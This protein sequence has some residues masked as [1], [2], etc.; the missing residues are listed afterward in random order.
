M[1]TRKIIVVP[2]MV[3]NWLNVSGCEKVVVRDGKL[4]A[5]EKR[6]DSA[7]DEKDQAGQHVKNGDA[8]VVDGR[9]PCESVVRT[10]G[11]IHDCVRNSAVVVVPFILAWRDMR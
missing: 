6:F 2:C 4:Q 3:N 11:R 7:D 10:L 9:Y 1:T 8:L 5:Y